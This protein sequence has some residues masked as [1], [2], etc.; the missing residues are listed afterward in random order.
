M[1]IYSCSPF[2]NEFDILDLKLSEESDAVDKIFLI[3]SNQSL[4]C[5]DKLLNLKGKEKYEN[6][7]KLVI[8]F[9]EDQFKPNQH[10]KNDILQKNSVLKFFDYE[11][12]DVLIC[13]DLDEINKKEDIPLI[14]SAAQEHGFVKLKMFCYYYKINLRRGD[15]KGW[16]S[17]FAITGKE[18]RERKGDIYGLRN[19]VRNVAMIN[20]DGKHFSY[21]TDPEGIAY[22]INNAG[23]PEFM[24]D[25]FTDEDKI[26]ERI[27]NHID[28]F[29]RL[30][31]GEIQKLSRVEVDETYPN[32]ILNNL[33]FWSKYIA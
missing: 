14:V 23:H 7:P 15:R 3:E 19:I 16:K 27:K 31:N 26:K 5:N 17:S 22:K 29:D 2:F 11:D 30:A 10:A 4:H 12:D 8:C 25:K 6:N 13:A 28:P 20:T 32:T 9:I 24:N 33:E 18:L 1:K 21:L